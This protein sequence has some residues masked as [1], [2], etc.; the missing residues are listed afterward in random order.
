MWC[1]KIVT[2][3]WNIGNDFMQEEPKKVLIVGGGDGGVNREVARYKSIE[4][5]HQAELDE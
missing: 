3:P 5:I 1:R 2:W 4:V